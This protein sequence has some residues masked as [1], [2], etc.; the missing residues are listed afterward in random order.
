MINLYK[1]HRPNPEFQQALVRLA[2][3]VFGLIYIG[4]GSYTGYYPISSSTYYNFAVI[5]LLYVIIAFWHVMLYPQVKYR[6]YITLFLDILASTYCIHLTGGASSPM[7]I[8]YVWI[9]VGQAVR[10]G[11]K[12]LYMSSVFSLLGY[13]SIIVY[14]QSWSLKTFEAVFLTLCLLLLPVYIDLMLKKTNI[15]RKEA[16]DANRAK[17]AFLANMSHEL[18]TPLNAIIGYSDMLVE[19]ARELGESQL[20]ADLQKIHMSGQH[21]LAL[22]TNILDLSKIEAGKMGVYLGPVDVR[23]MIE[24]V[25]ATVRS[26]IEEAGNEYVIEY[27]DEP[28]EIIADELKL[29]QVLINLLGN[30]AK[31]TE[32]GR[33]ELITRFER[34]KD[35]DWVFFKVRDNGIGIPPDQSGNLFSPFTQIDASTTRKFGGSGLGLS[36]SRSYCRMMGGDLT[37]QSLPGKG[38]CFEVSLPVEGLPSINNIKEKK[39]K[40]NEAYA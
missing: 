14:E 7:Y 17:S 29:K 23:R 8:M 36:I 38:S 40:K 34:I 9:F 13:S 19:D 20:S 12:N 16:D 10:F 35:D 25:G 28:V 32:N 37:L 22:I 30:A 2:I 6:S 24:E 31:F 3:Y 21:L 33:I 27:L 11:R 39:Y 5:F 4:L 15:A 18:R 1:K 26:L